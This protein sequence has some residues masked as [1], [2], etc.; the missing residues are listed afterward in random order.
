MGLADLI[1][2]APVSSS[3]VPRRRS[4]AR[5][6][7]HDRRGKRRLSGVHFG[8]QAIVGEDRRSRESTLRHGRPPIPAAGGAVAS[9][10]Q[11]KSLAVVHPIKTTL[12]R[13]AKSAKS[14]FFLS[15]P[16]AVMVA[17]V[18]KRLEG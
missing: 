9:D 17:I 8:R 12:S 10:W 5:F 6:G 1:L 7:V 18:T 11:S 15:R 16:R 14:A 2:P 13:A 3:E 4:L